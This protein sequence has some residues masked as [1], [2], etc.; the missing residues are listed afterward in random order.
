[1]GAGITLAFFNLASRVLGL[2]RDRILASNF[3]ASDIL[4]AYYVSF[5]IPDL[6][7][8]LLVAGAVSAAF[9][10]VFIENYEKAG[11]A[12]AKQKAEKLASNFLNI[13]LLAV[14]A[15]C[16]VFFVFAPKILTIIAPGFDSGKRE[17]AV[18]LT[19]IMIFSPIIFTVSI[20]AG[21]LLQIFH[22]FMAFAVAPLFYN[23]GIIFGA[24]VIVPMWG[25]VGLA[26]GVIF[27]AVLHMSVQLW[28]LRGVGIKWRP[29]FQPAEFEMRKIF[30][31]MIP[32]AIGLGATQINWIVLNA[33][34]ST[35]AVGS[36]AVLNF[37]NNLQYV[38][39]ALIGISAAVASF[40]TLSREALE[41]DK[42]KFASRIKQTMRKILFITIP[43]SAL[44]FIFA[45][46]LVGILL[47]A[48][49]FGAK[50]ISE[51]ANLLK[52]FGIG[53]FA[54]SVVPFLARAFYAIQDTQTPVWIGVFSVVLSVFIAFVGSFFI[55]ILALPLA[56]SVA[57]IIQAIM[58]WRYL[59][60]SYTDISDNR[61]R[62]FI[63]KIIFATLAMTLTVIGADHV[64]SVDGGGLSYY[65][66]HVTFAGGLG[67]LIFLLFC[68][69]IKI[70]EL[71]IVFK[72]GG[73]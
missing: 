23:A 3:G 53:I 13:M 29:V 62:S 37:A 7:F 34:A 1:M 46:D 72:K 47:G 66:L 31:L 57:G 28:G 30:R 42:I 50:N 19:R 43:L 64:L 16:A 67:L 52:L 4:D 60:E 54:Q 14:L 32:R 48:G 26:Y 27:G 5:N 55:G 40:P 65:V 18:L 36:V 6:I 21:S 49:L 71:E 69:I 68:V 58:L 22:R 61:W 8:N 25:P 20:V 38:P 39:V 24:L 15:L 17:L 51:T 11:D 2:L 45:E 59:A 35:V 70:E 73:F 44:T 9:I 12:E 41:E 56:V 10:P 33:I 63:F